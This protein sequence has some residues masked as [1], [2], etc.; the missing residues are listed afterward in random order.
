MYAGELVELAALLAIN[1][2]GVMRRVERWSGSG[3]RQYWLASKSRQERWNWAFKQ[4]SQPPPKRKSTQQREHDLTGPGSV[5]RPLLEEILISEILTRVW[6]AICCGCEQQRQLEEA[7]PLVR[8]V[9][10][11]H[12]EARHRSLNSLV[13]GDHLD[14]D[15]TAALDR[16]RRRV[17][18][19]NDLLL[20]YVA[21]SCDVDEFAFSPARTRDFSHDA[22]DASDRAQIWS[23]LMTS[24]RNT[25]RSGMAQPTRNHALNLRIAAGIVSSLPGDLVD[26]TGLM[27]SLWPL[28]M[29]H[30]A[31]DAA[32]LIEQLL[33]LEPPVDPL[34]VR[35]PACLP[36][37]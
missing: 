10:G 25:F 33:D 24:L 11:S 9:F 8:N 1:A 34:P 12:L 17:E 18:G 28:R 7:T 3:L 22:E 29:Q 5:L 20:G 4:C 19:W 15:T 21:E 6:T 23:L 37:G 13:S 16:L 35:G 14:A 27:R 26:S 30:V 2:S 36:P 32:R 31:Q